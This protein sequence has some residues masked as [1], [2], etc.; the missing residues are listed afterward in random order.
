MDK[1]EVEELCAKLAEMR[2]LGSEVRTAV[3]LPSVEACLRLSEMYIKW[4]QWMLGD[5]ERFDIEPD[6]MRSCGR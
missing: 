1:N 4:C 2:R 5:G 6:T 3:G